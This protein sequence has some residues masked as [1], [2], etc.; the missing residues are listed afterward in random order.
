[1]MQQQILRKYGSPTS[2]IQT[3]LLEMEILGEDDDTNYPG[4]PAG[5]PPLVFPDPKF[6]LQI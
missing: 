5:I 4:N 2:L 6:W 3:P 1:M